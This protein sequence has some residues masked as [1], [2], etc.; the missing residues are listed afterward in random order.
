MS[1]SHHKFF[2]A[3]LSVTAALSASCASAPSTPQTRQGYIAELMQAY[4]IEGVISRSQTEALA[5]AHRNIERVR[6][7]YGGALAGLSAAQRQ[8]VEAATDRFV[9]AA[10]VA[11]D[12]NEAATVWAQSFAANLTE[13]DLKRIVE[14]S[15]TPAGRAHIAASRDAT[16]QL[17]A[18]LVQKQNAN[19]DKAAQQYSAE[20]KAIV[21]APR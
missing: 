6:D 17:R 3:I 9:K 12:P 20:L 21:G 4:D 18:Y 1:H 7:Q 19:T 10:R 15:R 16:A 11:P 2:V 8:K 5:D 13:E 14:F